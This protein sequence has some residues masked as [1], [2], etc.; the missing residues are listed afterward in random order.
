MLRLQDLLQYR[1]LGNGV[2]DWALAALTFAVTLTVLPIAKG[3]IGARR[4]R[5]AGQELNRPQFP[6]AIELTTRVAIGDYLTSINS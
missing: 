5:R 4:R 1:F 2:A 3:F 6:G